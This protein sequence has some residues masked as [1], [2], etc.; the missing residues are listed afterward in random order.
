[1]KTIETGQRERFGRSGLQRLSAVATI[2]GLTLGV[3]NA[4]AAGADD[5]PLI[6]ADA[7]ADKAHAVVIQCSRLQSVDGRRR[8]HCD[9]SWTSILPP[10]PSVDIEKEITDFSAEMAKPRGG[11]VGSGFTKFCLDLATPQSAAWGVEEPEKSYIASVRQA[12]ATKSLEQFRQAYADNLRRSDGQTCKVWTGHGT[13]DFDQ[14]DANTWVSQ[15]APAGVCNVSAVSTLWRDAAE[16]VFWNYKLVQTSAPSAEPLCVAWNGKTTDE[17]YTWKGN[18]VRD[19]AH[20]LGCR[21][22]TFG[23]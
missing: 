10:R 2:A 9:I 15:A 18:K 20:E 17:E 6:A 14:V 13:D 11:K 4:S 3:P 16:P 8:I 21:Y 19:L 7:T 1:M 23:M 12:C 22:F 5:V